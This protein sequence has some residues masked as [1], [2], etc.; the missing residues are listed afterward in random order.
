MEKPLYGVKPLPK[1]PAVTRDL[2]LVVDES[3]GAGTMLETIRKAAKNLEDA[4][5]FDVYR[6]DKLGAGRK[7][8]AYA[9][10]FRAADRTLTDQEI[11][12][13][14]EKILRSVSETYG[15]ELRA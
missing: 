4:R 1:F 7:S 11:A 2:A 15:A 12:S 8:V 6:G 13:A 9:L 14:M 3:V 5:V 10:T